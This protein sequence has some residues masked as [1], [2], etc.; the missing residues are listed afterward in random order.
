MRHLCADH[1]SAQNSRLLLFLTC[2]SRKSSNWPPTRV[3]P[4]VNASDVF[5]FTLAGI[6]L[7]LLSDAVKRRAMCRLMPPSTIQSRFPTWATM[8]IPCKF[9]SHSLL[10]PFWPVKERKTYYSPERLS[11]ID[12]LHTDQLSNKVLSSPV[13]RI[14]EKLLV[15][16]GLNWV[17]SWHPNE[18]IPFTCVWPCMQVYWTVCCCRQNFNKKFKLNVHLIILP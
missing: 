6:N 12:T 3:G 8:M 7:T 17:V 5:T 18:Q 1:T 13:F 9:N 2:Q 16:S 11:S 4:N 15:E 14:W 10:E